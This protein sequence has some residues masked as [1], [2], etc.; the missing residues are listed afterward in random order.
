[1]I[2]IRGN[3]LIYRNTQRGKHVRPP[4]RKKKKKKK[5]HNPLNPTDDHSKLN[6]SNFPPICRYDFL[7]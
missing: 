1:M 7:G 2:I 4:S 5:N 6:A 3:E